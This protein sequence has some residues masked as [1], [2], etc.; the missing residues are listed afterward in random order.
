M[1]QT[2]SFFISPFGIQ[3][4]IRGTPQRALSG[5][6]S[7]Y[8]KAVT[9]FQNR[10]RSFIRFMKSRSC[11]QQVQSYTQ[12]NNNA[13]GHCHNQGS[14][15]HSILIPGG[16]GSRSGMAVAERR[17]ETVS[18]SPCHL[19]LP[20]LEFVPIVSHTRTFVNK[21][22]TTIIIL[23]YFAFL[24]RNNKCVPGAKKRGFTPFRRPSGAA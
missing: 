16:R 9:V 23:V 20:P 7:A 19:R 21:G 18:S 3:V 4:E 1:Q 15:H 22:N 6:A 11:R 2:F 5:L 14:V 12:Q 24:C 13:N 10:N 17:T 8:K